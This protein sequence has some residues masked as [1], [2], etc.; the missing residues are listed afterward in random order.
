MKP[1]HSR[2]ELGVH[3]DSDVLDDAMCHVTCSFAPPV[4]AGG[5]TG[6]RRIVRQAVRG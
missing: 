4:S 1:P 5:V 3:S 6:V 2:P